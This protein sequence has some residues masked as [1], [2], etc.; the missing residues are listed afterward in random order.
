MLMAQ[1]RFILN[2]VRQSGHAS[3]V[4]DPLPKGFAEATLEGVSRANH[5]AARAMSIPGIAEAGWTIQDI[6]GATGPGKEADRQ[7]TALKTDL[8][9]M[10]RKV[11]EQQFAWP[12]RE[13]VDTKEVPDYLEVIKHPMDLQTIEKRIRQDNYYKN[14]EM[15]IE[16]LMLVSCI[17]C[18]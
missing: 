17:L 4:Y 13:P 10:V 2:R 14:K 15:F 9:T 5:A 7:K 18:W 8:L 6:R 3:K 11:E 1:R 16:D 12:F